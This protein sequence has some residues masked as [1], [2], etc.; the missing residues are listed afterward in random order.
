MFY[1][2]TIRTLQ[3]SHSLNTQTWTSQEMECFGSD[4]QRRSYLFSRS[5]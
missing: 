4:R 5:K 1:Q 2:N 3:I